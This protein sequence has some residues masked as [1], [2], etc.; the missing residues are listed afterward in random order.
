MPPGV[1]TLHAMNAAQAVIVIGGFLVLMSVMVV[2]MIRINR[3]EREI[4]ERRHEEWIARGSIPE[5]KPNFFSGN[6]GG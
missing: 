1:P 5:E 3:R 2:L 4:M 6:P